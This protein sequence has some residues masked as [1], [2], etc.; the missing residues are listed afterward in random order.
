MSKIKGRRDSGLGVRRQQVFTHPLVAR[1]LV[2]GG[3]CNAEMLAERLFEPPHPYS[4]VTSQIRRGEE[5]IGRL[6][7]NSV[8]KSSERL[9]GRPRRASSS[10]VTADFPILTQTCAASWLNHGNRVAPFGVNTAATPGRASTAL[11]PNA[12]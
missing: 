12:S 10:V 7:E 4:G 9:S 6:F 2:E 3:R 8:S 11:S 1:S 5:R